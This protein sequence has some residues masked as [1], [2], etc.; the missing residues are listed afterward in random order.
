MEGNGDIA[1]GWPTKSLTVN[2][3]RKIFYS[4][5]KNKFSRRIEKL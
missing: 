5:D 3:S 4:R 1:V 2:L